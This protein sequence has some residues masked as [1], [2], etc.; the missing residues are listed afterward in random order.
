[1]Q[2]AERAVVGNVA[3]MQLPLVSAVVVVAE[4]NRSPR[5]TE[6]VL[7]AET[8]ALPAIRTRHQK[9]LGESRA[10]SRSMM[11]SLKFKRFWPR[12]SHQPIRIKFQGC[13]HRPPPQ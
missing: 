9:I 6:M 13:G 8:T 10:I 4:I 7:R 5:R 12:R 2:M 1:W 3:A 11:R